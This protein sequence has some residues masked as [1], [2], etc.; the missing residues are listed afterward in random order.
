MRKKAAC[1]LALLLA[2]ALCVPAA[3]EAN[4]ESAYQAE[5][6]LQTVSCA[7]Q[8]FSTMVPTGCF[9]DYHPDEGLCIYTGEGEG[10]PFV[11]MFK[12]DGTGFDAEKHFSDVLT[13]QMKQNYGDSLTNIGDYGIWDVAGKQMPGQMYSYTIEDTSVVLLRVFDIR[14]DSFVCY[15]AKYLEDDP[16]ATLGALAT[17]VYYYQPDSEI[18]SGQDSAP[19]PGSKAPDN[20]GTDASPEP[21]AGH[22]DVSGIDASPEPST[23]TPDITGTDASPEPP[24]GAPDVTGTDAS[25]EPPTGAPDGPGTDEP[26]SRS[27]NGNSVISVESMG[28]SVLYDPAYTVTANSDD[29]VTIYTGPEDS[30]PYVI[31][32][33]SE[34]L[35]DGWEYLTEMLTPRII[36]QYG[37]DLIE[38]KEYEHYSVGGKE[39]PAGV[40]T[41]NLQGYTVDLIKVFDSVDGHTVTYTAKYIEGQDAETLAALDLA[42]ASYQPDPDYYTEY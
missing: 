6:S 23:G 26:E 12:A 18:V 21:P 9:Y 29:G 2:G 13:P 30:I 40:Y 28:F 37:S 35:V 4:E 22:P 7:E 39:L 14:E 17:A 10:I 3:A 11:L 27:T 19:V 8:G 25:P 24:T 36:D 38:Y 1:L 20:T 41:Y 31:V 42:A 34:D 15:T 5:P 16:D 32:F 33:R